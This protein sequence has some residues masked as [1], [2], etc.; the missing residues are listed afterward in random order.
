MELKPAAVGLRRRAKGGPSKFTLS[1]ESGT[2]QNTHK[3]TLFQ[4]PI[5]ERHIQLI[6]VLFIVFLTITN[7]NNTNNLYCMLLRKKHYEEEKEK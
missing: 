4:L 6:Y 7:N 1:I 3:K 2:K 5:P